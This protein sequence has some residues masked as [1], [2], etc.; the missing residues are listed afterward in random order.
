MGQER[1]RMPTTTAAAEPEGRGQRIDATG[2]GMD[3]TGGGGESDGGH[4]GEKMCG[5]LYPVAC[6]DAAATACR[7]YFVSGCAWFAPHL[8]ALF[9]CA[10]HRPARRARPSPSPPPFACFLCDGVANSARYQH[11]ARRAGHA[12]R[13]CAARQVALG[14][15]RTGTVRAAPASDVIGECTV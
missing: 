5:R 6:V 4:E 8:V 9:Y 11:P 12:W 10:R 13:L 7:P 3:A 2:G 1:Q 14:W 15:W